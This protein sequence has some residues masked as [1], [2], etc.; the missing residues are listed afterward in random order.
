MMTRHEPARR[1]GAAGVRAFLLSAALLAAPAAAIGQ[2]TAAAPVVDTQVKVGAGLYEL[3]VNEP[4]N[5]V[6]VASTG[7][8]APRIYE[9]D[10][11]TLAEKRVIDLEVPAF[12]LG[13]NRKTQTLYTSNTRAGSVS[14]IDLKSGR[15]VATISEDGNPS[16]HTFRVVVDEEANKVYV[17]IVADPSKV[18]VI[19][20]ATNTLEHVIEGTGARS[21]GLALDRAGNR[22]F[23][24]SQGTNEVHEIDL[25]KRAV[26]RSYPT[27]GERPTQIVYDDA[28]GRLFITHQA[29]NN[30]TAVDT[31]TGTLLRAVDTD[32]QALG[33]GL[34]PARN[35]LY[36]ANRGGGSVTVIDATSYAV[37]TTLDAGTMPNTVAIDS[38]DGTVFVTNKA[39]PTGRRGGG[40]RAGAAPA[41]PAPPSATGPAQAPPPDEGGDTV[42]RITVP[43]A[44]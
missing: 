38:R 18:W 26:V 24:V 5:A 16:A 44:R 35:L 3:V 40:G 19:D 33:I 34:D 20:G 32:R 7:N 8:N 9:I 22:L 29:T 37:V 25:A 1:A 17:S 11:T 27:G 42:T 10:A 14:A 2:T 4:A 28:T 15:V 23:T 13:L 30:V 12:G 36:V 39:R 41:A 43:A 31:K 6:L 21:T